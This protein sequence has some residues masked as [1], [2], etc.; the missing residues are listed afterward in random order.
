MILGRFLELVDRGD[1]QVVVDRPRRRRSDARDAKQREQARRHRR[2]QL[3]VTLRATGRDELFDRLGDGW[4]HLG[5][6]LEA[7]FLDKLRE[8]LSQI[9]D[10]AR[11]RAVGD[12]TENV[13]AFELDEV[14]DLVEDPRDGVVADGKCVERHRAM[15]GLVRCAPC[16]LEHVVR[17]L[18]LATRA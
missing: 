16:E 7:F 10:R 9:S 18:G 4:P 5:D 13:L 11:G 2:L 1:L 6:F 15:L 8:R 3:L 12:G 14:A 17:G